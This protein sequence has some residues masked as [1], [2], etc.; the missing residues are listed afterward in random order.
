MEFAAC[1]ENCKW[2]ADSYFTR[3]YERLSKILR[4]GMKAGELRKIDPAHAVPALVGMILHSFIMRPMAEYVMGSKLD[5]SIARFGKFV[6]ET[7]FDGICANK[8]A[9]SRSVSVRILR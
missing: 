1:S 3:S 7:F 2:L 5:L 4:Q 8:Q 9:K 6:T